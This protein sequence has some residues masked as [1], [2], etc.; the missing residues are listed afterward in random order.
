LTALNIFNLGTT[1]FVSLTFDLRVRRDGSPPLVS[2]TGGR[3][4]SNAAA[5]ARVH[6][7]EHSSAALSSGGLPI[8]TVD[9]RCVDAV[10]RSNLHAENVR[11][12]W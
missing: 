5:V 1:L 8:C 3:S 7:R 2:A 12:G 6:G 9:D 4:S 11:M 10:L